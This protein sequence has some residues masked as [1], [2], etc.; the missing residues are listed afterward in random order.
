MSCST[1]ICVIVRETV[2]REDPIVSAISRWG[3]R[4]TTAPPPPAFRPRVAASSRKYRAS[5]LFTSS[6]ASPSIVALARRNRAEK[7]ARSA[8]VRTKFDFRRSRNTARDRIARSDFSWAMTL[9][10][11]GASSRRAISPKWSPSQRVLSTTSRPSGATMATAT[12]PRTRTKTAPRGWPCCTIVSPRLYV[13]NVAARASAVRSS[14]ETPSKR[15]TLEKSSVITMEDPPLTGEPERRVDGGERLSPT[16]LPGCRLGEYAAGGEGGGREKARLVAAP[17]KRGEAPEVAGHLASGHR[18]VGP[19]EVWPPRDEKESE[20]DRLDEAP[21]IRAVEDVDR[22]VAAR[23]HAG[24][25]HLG[26]E[27]EEQGRELGARDAGSRDG[28]PRRGGKILHLKLEPRGRLFLPQGRVVLGEAAVKSLGLGEARRLER[29]RRERLG[30][31]G[32]GRCPRMSRLG[33]RPCILEL[34]LRLRGR[35]EHVIA[36]R[37]LRGHLDEN[38]RRPACRREVF[39]RERRLGLS[40]ESR[41]VRRAELADP[42][43]VAGLS[44]REARRV[45]IRVERIAQPPGNRVVFRARREGGRPRL[46]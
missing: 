44:G 9:A 26:N 8:R 25:R 29:E 28:L 5:R 6:D 41:H 37:R 14:A 21:A 30:Q 39:A 13:R 11:R 17:E 16:D 27:R 7:V 43:E 4:T 20:R 12:R 22:H 10:D 46:G 31:G 18:R 2:S 40:A 24:G 19:H 32:I 33:G 35:R 23:R 42:F 38:E 15:G 45:A 34:S 3:G 36:G 1:A